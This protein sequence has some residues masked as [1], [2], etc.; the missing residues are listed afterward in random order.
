MDNSEQNIHKQENQG[1]ARIEPY[2]QPAGGWGALLSVA[3]NL[4]RQDVLKK[5]SITLLNINQPTGFDC[6]GCAWPE[7]KDT[8]AFNFCENGAK[9]VAF[10]ATSKTVTPEFFAKH[11]VSWL[12]EQSDFY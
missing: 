8:H 11:T 1:Y 12:S 4:K 5:G 6:P 10:E 3:R 7:K 9:A 2:T